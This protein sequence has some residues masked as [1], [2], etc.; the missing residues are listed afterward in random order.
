MSDHAPDP[1]PTNRPQRG[2]S[3]AQDADQARLLAGE[4]V[5]LV[6]E[7]T[8][9]ER[10]R[11]RGQAALVHAQLAQASLLSAILREL[12]FQNEEVQP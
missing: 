12:R 9:E 4:A 8:P 6:N 11:A 10:S 3:P 2:A 7:S 1:N 5:R